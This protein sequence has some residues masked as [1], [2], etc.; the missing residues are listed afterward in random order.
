MG[1]VSCYILAPSV[2]VVGSALLVVG[3]ASEVEVGVVTE[4]EAEVAFEVEA[5]V[6]SSALS[7]IENRK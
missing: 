5:N 7:K 1:V 4:L 2:D 6:A 3:V